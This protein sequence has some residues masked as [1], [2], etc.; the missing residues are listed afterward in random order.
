MRLQHIQITSPAC[1]ELD[2][3]HTDFL[4]KQNTPDLQIWSAVIVQNHIF[5]GLPPLKSPQALLAQAP[6]CPQLEL[7]IE[8]LT[9]R[10]RPDLSEPGSCPT[11]DPPLHVRP[12]GSHTVLSISLYNK[13]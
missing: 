6:A 1:P 2:G 5:P 13:A 8:H 10:L 11:R 9:Y 3:H 4:D 12:S 7:H